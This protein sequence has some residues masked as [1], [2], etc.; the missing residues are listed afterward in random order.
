MHWADMRV[1]Q[2]R[3]R[4]IRRHISV[5]GAPTSPGRTL[6]TIFNY[7][8]WLVL[9]FIEETVSNKCAPIKFATDRYW[10]IF[11]HNTVI[12]GLYKGWLKEPDKC[13]SLSMCNWTA[14]GNCWAECPIVPWPN[15]VCCNQAFTATEHVFSWCYYCYNYR[16]ANMLRCLNQEDTANPHWN[17]KEKS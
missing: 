9:T 1:T 8:Q 2:P 12:S 15:R 10:P 11:I 14:A 6:Y 4:I 3:S 17:C 7:F 5:Q 13:A 16:I